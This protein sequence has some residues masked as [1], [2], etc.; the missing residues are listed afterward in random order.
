MASRRETNNTYRKMLSQFDKTAAPYG[1]TQQRWSSKEI[2]VTIRLTRPKPYAKTCLL[3]VN[4][5]VRLA[6]QYT[7]FDTNR[8]NSS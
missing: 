3:F 5:L 2:N 8:D 1:H 4:R 7:K 6:D